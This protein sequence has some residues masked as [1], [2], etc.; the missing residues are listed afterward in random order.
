MA[1]IT[2]TKEEPNMGYYSNVGII[3]HTLKP[4]IRIEPY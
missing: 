1:Y 2:G 4:E 3:K